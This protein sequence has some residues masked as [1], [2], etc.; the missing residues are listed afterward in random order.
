[1]ENSDTKLYMIYCRICCAN[2][3]YRTAEVTISN[4]SVSEC[5]NQVQSAVTRL[6]LHVDVHTLVQTVN[7]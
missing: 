2:E 4:V 6:E 7:K 5:S 1:M 3:C